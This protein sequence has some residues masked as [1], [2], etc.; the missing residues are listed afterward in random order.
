MLGRDGRRRD[1]CDGGPGHAE[2]VHDVVPALS[3]PH[4]RE[5]A[6]RP[7]CNA[8]V[9]GVAAL[10]DLGLR[11][12]TAGLKRDADHDRH[13]VLKCRKMVRPPRVAEAA[14]VDA[15]VPELGGAHGKVPAAAPVMLW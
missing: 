13:V 2:E 7:T 11:S 4:S 12:D 9:A 1:P 14:K 10:G 3:V 5:A 15:C 6:L 8:E